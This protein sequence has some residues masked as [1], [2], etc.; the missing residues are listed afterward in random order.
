NAGIRLEQP[1]KPG[2]GA[3]KIGQALRSACLVA[4]MGL[5]LAGCGVAVPD[6]GRL[7][8]VPASRTFPILPDYDDPIWSAPQ[9]LPLNIASLAEGRHAVAGGE[10]FILPYVLTRLPYKNLED[11][12]A[13]VARMNREHAPDPA[14]VYRPERRLGH[15]KCAST[16]ASTLIDW[17]YLSQ[18]RPLGS[19]RSWAH[20]R[21]ERGYDGRKIDALYYRFARTGEFG[22]GFTTLRLYKDPVEGNAIPFSP[23]GF[24]KIIA[25]AG[26][27]AFP[28]NAVL[29]A[30]DATLP[31]VVH[32]ARVSDFLDL[33]PVQL[34]HDDPVRRIVPDPARF[35]APLVEALDKDGPLYASVRFRFTRD[36]AEGGHN[37]AGGMSTEAGTVKVY[38]DRLPIPTY[39]GHCVVIVGYVKQNGRVYF[40]YRETFG[41]YDV[42]SEKGGAAYRVL[43]VHGFAKAF[44]FR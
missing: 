33:K 23:D 8:A 28:R 19:Y 21:T 39:A 11:D 25:M 12:E 43:P 2:L 15:Y 32:E 35:S 26:A 3:M 10:M 38:G 30:D 31:G 13:W 9:G 42:E 27:G 14:W 37:K 5:V 7:A 29:K 17:F 18:G 6:I 44:A 4:M 1:G 34:L 40:I 41:K 16:S 24:A 36:Q 22:S 20:G